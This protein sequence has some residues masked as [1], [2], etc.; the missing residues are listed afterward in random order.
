MPVETR[1]SVG[2]QMNAG[3]R[4]SQIN[5]SLLTSLLRL[6]LWR[7]L[8]GAG[9]SDHH[10]HA[11]RKVVDTFCSLA[12]STLMAVLTVP[13]TMCTDDNVV[14][15]NRTLVDRDVKVPCRLSPPVERDPG[16]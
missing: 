12:L 8:P 11:P 14:N 16:A 1:F 9:R 6:C 10:A 15:T 3:L 7:K 2:G 13:T 4:S 5:L